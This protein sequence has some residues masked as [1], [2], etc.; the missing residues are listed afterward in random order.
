MKEGFSDRLRQLREA[1]GLT[2][3]QL[4]AKMFVNRS[5]IARWESGIRIPDLFLIE[6][7]AKCL[8]V[9]VAELFSDTARS[10]QTRRIILVDDEK[11]ILAGELRVLEKTIPGYEITG[12]TKSSEALEFARSHPVQLAFLDIEMGKTSGFELCEQLTFLNP[13]TNVVFLTAWPDHSLQAWK[14]DACGFLLKPL[15]EEDVLAILKKLKH[16]I[17]NFLRGGTEWEA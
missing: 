3:Q 13:S 11:P 2:Q 16:P 1:K 12:F 8:D 10:A 9:E 17:P 4:A 5:S 14:T 7:L 6:R 15:T